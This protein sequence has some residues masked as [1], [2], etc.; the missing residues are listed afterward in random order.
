[1]LLMMHFKHTAV[2]STCWVL[3]T[4]RSLTSKNVLFEA[5]LLTKSGYG[6]AV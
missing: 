2:Y 4:G 3:D 5:S 6:G 1:M